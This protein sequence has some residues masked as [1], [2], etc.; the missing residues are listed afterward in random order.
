M[1]H[2]TCNGIFHAYYFKRVVNISLPSIYILPLYGLQHSSLW[3]TYRFIG[4]HLRMH[5]FN[6]RVNSSTLQIFEEVYCFTPYAILIIH[7]HR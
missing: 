3:E 7:P 1:I 4:L 6:E 2:V 5:L